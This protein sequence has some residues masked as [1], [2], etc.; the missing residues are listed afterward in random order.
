MKIIRSFS[1]VPALPE[2]LKSLYKIANNLWWCWNP[3]AVELFRRIDRVKW[4][5][6]NHN[7]VKLLGII[8]QERLNSLADNES[9]MDHLRRI[10]LALDEYM[11]EDTWFTQCDGHESNARFAYFSAE[12]GLHESIPIY[13][14]GLGILA[15]DHLKSASEVGIPLVGVGLLYRQGY[16]NQYLNKDGWQQEEYRVNDFYAMPL[17]LMK[18]K[19]ENPVMISVKLDGIDVYAQI[20]KLQVGRVPLYLL[21]ANVAKNSPENRRITANLYGGDQDMRMRQEI[22]LGIGGIRALRAL[23][24][25]VDICHMNEGH[26]AFLAL[27]R[28]RVYMD[29]QKLTFAQASEMVKAATIFTTH[30]PVPAGNDRFDEALMT[31]YFKDY[32][33]LLGLRTDEFMALGRENIYDAAELFCMTVLALNFSTYAN[34]VSEL[35][36][37][38]SR[39][40]WRKMWPQVAEKD[41]PISSITNG[42]HTRSWTADEL[43]I[44][45]DR[46]LG[47]RWSE[48]AADTEVW[49]RAHNI[50]NYELWRGHERLRERLVTFVRDRLKKQL[51]RRGASADEI[52]Q[53]EQVLDPDALTIGFARRFATYKRAGLI[54]SDLDRL[55]EIVNNKKM[56]VQIVF[57]GKAHPHDTQGKELI[58]EIVHLS[59]RPELRN[60]IVFIEDYDIRVARY[61]VQGVDVWLNN[62][63]KPLEASGT[64]GMKVV[65]NG[66]LN[67][68]ILDGWW[69]EAYNTENGWALGGGEQ[70]ADTDTQDLIESKSLYDLLERE[71]APIFYRRGGDGIPREWMTMMKKSMATL[72]PEFNTNRMVR[73]YYA[74]GYHPAFAHMIELAANDYARAKV[75]AAWKKKM[76]TEWASIHIKNV[77]EER[78][79]GVTLGDSF[80]VTVSLHLGKIM[81]DE[82]SAQ[83]CTG[84]LDKEGQLTE[85][86]V[87]DMTYV[88]DEGHAVHTFEGN[89]LGSLS[90]QNGFA[91]RVLPKHVDL[92]QPF[93]RGL[94]YWV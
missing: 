12:F 43:N 35:H 64:S 82:V 87:S 49:Q 91:I 89:V 65:P 28:L 13:S 47:T 88:K 6:V 90:G 63:R 7:P 57:A 32:Y 8:S 21:D 40:M 10:E 22:L 18:D 81:P 58:K 23:N 39:K 27:E 92:V 5:E 48:S 15:G 4:R 75:L 53:A 55:T 14:G 26:S 51:I 84:A 45:F 41:I 2:Q 19:E 17:T 94:I 69:C 33:A 52:S 34:G 24:V 66:G 59:R 36:G 37:E 93:M 46:Y 77:V 62:P 76:Q 56:P 60:K 3:E 25:K 42:I 73:D 71:V 67:L 50:P 80:P 61:L 72:C 9:F 79:D 38:V 83:I 54:F 68:S 70:Y 44:L 31:R 11:K 30:T 74:N 20:W 86:Q 85:Y 29:E 16:F 1:V 78:K